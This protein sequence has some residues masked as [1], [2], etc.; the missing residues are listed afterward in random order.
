MWFYAKF[1]VT[2]SQGRR[3]C[4]ASILLC[5]CRVAAAALLLQRYLS[6]NRPKVLFAP[7]TH[8]RD[9]PQLTAFA[10][11]LVSLSSPVFEGG[12]GGQVISRE[13]KKLAESEKKTETRYVSNLLHGINYGNPHKVCHKQRAPTDWSTH[14]SKVYSKTKCVELI[15]QI[16]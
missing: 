14:I 7:V 9:L 15:Q 10:L 1:N 6:P 5:C 11:Q 3:C 12:V 2:D 8:L 16:S 13:L 4:W